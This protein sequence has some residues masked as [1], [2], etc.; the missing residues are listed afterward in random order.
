MSTTF[1]KLLKFNS[2]QEIDSLISSEGN[3]LI[4]DIVLRIKELENKFNSQIE[5]Q[6]KE[7]LC[8]KE[9]FKEKD[10]KQ[11]MQELQQK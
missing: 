7:I 5:N 8:L 9:K 11:Q 1:E 6:E 10:G 4:Y 2:K 3:D